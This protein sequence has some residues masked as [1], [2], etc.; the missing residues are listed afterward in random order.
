MQ[1]P[2]H[3]L[4]GVL[5][6]RAVRRHVNSRFDPLII[7]T[8]GLVSHMLLDRVAR[9]TY[10]PAKAMP[11]D[12]FW[13]SYHGLLVAATLLALKLYWPDHKLGILAA[14]FPDI[15]WIVFRPLTTLFPQLDALQGPV[16]HQAMMALLSAALPLHVFDGLPDWTLNEATVVIELAVL[17]ALSAALQPRPAPLPQRDML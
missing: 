11:R 12:P 5:I 13:L 1:A 4:T 16:T 9:L 6:E 3:I 10:H 7:V 8:S 17:A 14:V 2:T 15:D